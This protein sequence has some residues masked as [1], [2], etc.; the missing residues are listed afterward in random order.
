M[1]QLNNGD[2]VLKIAANLTEEL[3]LDGDTTNRAHSR[4]Y[5]D[6]LK[7][8]DISLETYPTNPETQSL[9]DT[10]FNLCRQPTGLAGLGAMCL[11]A[12]GLVPAMYSRIV[13][14]FR[15]HNVDFRQLEFFT[16]HIECDDGHAA[17]MNDILARQTENAP[18][19]LVTAL[20]AGDVAVSAR[21]RFFDALMTKVN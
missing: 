5:A 2:D 20:N 9:I 6:M 1:S 10:M 4:I 19:N 3:G 12:E 18:S 7:A 11:G 13:Q 21:L 17:T 15:H 16:I 8:F 14:G